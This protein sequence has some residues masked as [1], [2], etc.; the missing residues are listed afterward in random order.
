MLNTWTHFIEFI[1]L[2]TGEERRKS[3]LDGTYQSEM[4]SAITVG[5]K[6]ALHHR[7]PDT[8]SSYNT[9]EETSNRKSFHT[10]SPEKDG[11]S[12]L[13]ELSQVSIKTAEEDLEEVKEEFEKFEKPPFRFVDKVRTFAVNRD[14]ELI[15][16]HSDSD[17]SHGSAINGNTMGPDLTN[18]SLT[19]RDSTGKYLTTDNSYGLSTHTI[20]ETSAESRLSEFSNLSSGKSGSMSSNPKSSSFTNVTSDPSLDATGASILSQYTL[21]DTKGDNSNRS[22]AVAESL[23]EQD[24]VQ[25]RFA[26]LD[27]LISE[28]KHLIAKHKQVIERTK[29]ISPELPELPK[30]PPPPLIKT[31]EIT[32]PTISS[33]NGE[34][35]F[36]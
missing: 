2:F 18:Y 25:D 23:T 35:L 5:D 30:Q 19:S 21:N 13:E 26:S 17:K 3:A 31:G 36:V 8:M 34:T 22:A 15:S 27:N 29:S 12:T 10:L 4:P 16:E 33:Y 24:Y 1:T 6:S 9:S 11:G 28:S 32:L 20:P 14:G 7:K